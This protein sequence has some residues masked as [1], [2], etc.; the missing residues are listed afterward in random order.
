MSPPG[1][2]EPSNVLTK[3]SYVK[4][5][6]GLHP[7]DNKW[8]CAIKGIMKAVSVQV[9]TY[10]DRKFRRQSA[11]EY[12]ESTHQIGNSLGSF[13]TFEVPDY[14]WPEITPIDQNATILLQYSFNREWDT[15]GITF[16]KDKDF[17]IETID[18]QAGQ[19]EVIRVF[20]SEDQL[21]NLSNFPVTS[22]NHFS[23]HPHVMGYRLTYTGGFAYVPAD[24][25]PCT[26]DDY[27]DVHEGLKYIVANKV[28]RVFKSR[29]EEPIYLTDEDK[30]A[31]RPFM[32]HGRY[33]GS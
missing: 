11:V 9:E 3:L 23:V 13:I 10:C 6:L 18:G 12:H 29:M 15:S 27:V 8:D 2:P 7:Q 32:R 33:L 17:F 30:K 1:V 21:I 14:I 19:A 28:A 24:D 22:F 4:Q 25:E 16:V 20:P 26:D 31:L 5:Q